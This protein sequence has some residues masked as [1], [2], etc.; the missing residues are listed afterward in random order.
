MIKLPRVVT[1]SSLFSRFAED[2]ESPTMGGGAL[3]VI[4]A[5]VAVERRRLEPARRTGIPKHRRCRS[6]L[7]RYADRGGGDEKN[8]KGRAERAHESYFTL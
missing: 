8:E 6:C 7:G 3:H 1:I 5:L 4:D 2:M